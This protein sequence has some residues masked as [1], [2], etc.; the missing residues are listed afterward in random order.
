MSETMTASPVFE[1][2]FQN[3]RKAT[4]ATLKMQQEIYSQWASLWPGVHTPQTAL[5][6]QVQGFRKHWIETTSLLARKHRDVI[7]RR[8]QAAIESLD[9]ALSITDAST[10]EEFRRRSE[11]FCR[12]T[13]DC[14]KEMTE[15]QIR[16][17]QEAITK[18]TDLL[19]KA[20]P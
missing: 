15:S 11:Q 19:A 2:V 6:N 12:K 5:L 20:G 4:E 9:A 13:L 1:E 14:M 8:Y 7:E 10:P 17:F 18:W 16:E 3:I